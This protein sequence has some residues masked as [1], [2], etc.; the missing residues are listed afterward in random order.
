MIEVY[1]LLMW[2]V[3]FP[4]KLV[5]DFE[6]F[7]EITERLNLSEQEVNDGLDGKVI[8]EKYIL[9]LSPKWLLELE[10]EFN[11]KQRLTEGM[12]FHEI[13]IKLN[14][15]AESAYKRFSRA[16]KKMDRE[17]ILIPFLLNLVQLRE[18]QNRNGGNYNIR[19]KG[20]VKISINN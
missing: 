9:E 12:D 19:I 6:T 8:Q 5:G 14:I 18:L 20:S 3:P 1:E 15:G 16:Q 4:R 17:G 10:K 7:E 11:K 2:P 13:A